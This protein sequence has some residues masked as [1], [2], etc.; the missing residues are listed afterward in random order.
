MKTIHL[1]VVIKKILELAVE[2][3]LR[4]NDYAFN[5]CNGFILL[6]DYNIFIS[7]LKSI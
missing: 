3:N 7:Q 5:I 2:N 1:L 6:D 4:I